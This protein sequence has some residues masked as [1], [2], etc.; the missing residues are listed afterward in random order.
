MGQRFVSAV[1]VLDEDQI[2]AFARD[3]DPQ[4]FHLSDEGAAGTI[5]GTLA[6]SG[7]HTMAITMRLL[8]DSVPLAAGLIGA[9]T[10]VSW[11][12]PTRPGSQLQVFSEFTDIRPS[13]S[14]PGMAIVTMRAETR[15][16]EG[17]VLQVFTAKMP[18]FRRD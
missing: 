10:E 14:R 15:D 17:Q 4:P 1:H 18:V 13:R 8:V 11:P 2:K 3:F 5:F 6:A 12:R 16:Q 7:W 9:T